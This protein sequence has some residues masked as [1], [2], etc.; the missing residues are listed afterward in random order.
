MLELLN[1]SVI[2][3]ATGL[4]TDEKKCMDSLV[5]AYNKFAELD[6]QHPDEL[7]EFTD[8]IHNLQ[9]LLS[10]RIVRR[11]YPKGW[12]TYES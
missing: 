9:N 6:R 4:T 2:D 12:P 8:G 1:M 5:N 10:V 3:S 11:V 7:K